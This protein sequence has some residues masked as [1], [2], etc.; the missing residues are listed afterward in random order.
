MYGY[1]DRHVARLPAHVAAD[2]GALNAYTPGHAKWDYGYVLR[3]RPPDAFFQ[4]WQLTPE[5][6]RVLLGA[7]GYVRDGDFWILDGSEYRSGVAAAER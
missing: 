6:A 2:A 3:E 7:H 5:R 4:A 1:S